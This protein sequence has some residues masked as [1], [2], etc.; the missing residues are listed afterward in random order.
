MPRLGSLILSMIVLVTTAVVAAPAPA[1]A[2]TF[3]TLYA[4]G[5]P[6]LDGRVQEPTD[7]DD[8]LLAVEWYPTVDGA[9]VGGRIC[10]DREVPQKPEVF[11]WGADGALLGHGAFSEAGGVSAPCFR[12][13]EF[14]MVRVE[15]GTHYVLGMWV[16]GGQYSYVPEGLAS[17]VSNVASGGH[18][19]ATSAGDS[20]HGNG[21]YAYTPNLGA[22]TPFP[23]STWEDSDYLVSPIFVP[24]AG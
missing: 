5:D 17:E 3:E 9:V 20:P 23:V 21:L 19:V 2:F 22:D 12:D 24:S 4:T 8:V 16:R 18:L 1:G 13:V 10:L 14:G 15:A 7:T 6:Y 11:L